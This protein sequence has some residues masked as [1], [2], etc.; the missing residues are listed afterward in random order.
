MSGS[1]V[2]AL[3]SEQMRLARRRGESRTDWARVR[4]EAGKGPGAAATNRHIGEL[5]ERKRGRPVVGEPKT[6]ISLR[7]PN[8]ILA[9]WKA[10]GP[11]WQTRM[12]K[13]LDKALPRKAS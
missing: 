1:K 4:R 2:T 5:I 6:A 12:A 11:G 10:T 13:A 3:T 9:R 7:I 8:S